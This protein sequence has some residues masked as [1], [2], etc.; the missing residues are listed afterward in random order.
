MK[1]TLLCLV[2]AALTVACG[3]EKAAPQVEDQANVEQTIHTFFAALN[4]Y[5]KDTVE[6]MLAPDGASWIA[7]LAYSESMKLKMSVDKIGEP[8]ID[9][10]H[11]TVAITTTF[12]TTS[13]L[14]PDEPTSTQDVFLTRINGKWLMS[15]R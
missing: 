11:C 10:D 6:S 15:A 12:S 1:I 2:L 3:D 13:G 5:D 8:R 7:T 9:G 4:S 14:K